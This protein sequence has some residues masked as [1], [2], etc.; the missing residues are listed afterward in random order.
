M[1]DAGVKLGGIAAS[2]FPEEREGRRQSARRLWSEARL[3]H[4]NLN[5]LMHVVYVEGPSRMAHTAQAASGALVS[6]FSTVIDWLRAVD[7]ETETPQHGAEWEIAHGDA[8]SKLLEFLY[9]AADAL[10]QDTPD[11][12]DS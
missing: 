4:H 7:H 8:Y 2:D 11:I 5:R 12:R 9:A 3:L 10:M 6:D 1:T